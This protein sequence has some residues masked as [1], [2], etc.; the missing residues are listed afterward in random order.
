MLQREID[1]GL[2]KSLE[3]AGV[4]P[5]S[6]KIHRHHFLLLAQLAQAVGELDLAPVAWLQVLQN[7]KD[8]G[9]QYIPAQNGVVGKD[10]LQTG[11]FHHVGHAEHPLLQR[12]HLHRAIFA[13]GRRGHL[14]NPHRG[15]VIPLCHLDQLGGHRLLRAHDVVAQQ[16]GEGLVSHKALG[17]PNGVAQAPGLLLTHIEDVGQIGGAA[18]LR[19]LPVLP[20]LVEA[21]LQ[22]GIVVEV[23]VHSGLGPVGDDQDILDPRRRGLFNKVLNGGL[24]HQGQHLLGDG[25]GCGEHPGTQPR[26][27]DHGFTDLHRKSP[28]T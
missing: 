26:G 3:V 4:V 21:G 8:T 6:L 16:H 19:Q 23:V 14:L 27:G 28:L 13:D 25:F 7:V 17:P 11:L 1:G 12:L 20:R 24:V 5:L 22:L 18:H 10:L 2:Q 9:G 15:G